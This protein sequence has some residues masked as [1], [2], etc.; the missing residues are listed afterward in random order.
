MQTQPIIYREAI[1]KFSKLSRERFP[2][3]IPLDYFPT[4]QSQQL[5]PYGP[6]PH[7]RECALNYFFV[8]TPPD[9]SGSTP[10]PIPIADARRRIRE[11]HYDRG[12][13]VNAMDIE[14]KEMADC[15][16]RFDSFSKSEH[17]KGKVMAYQL[18]QLGF[19]FVG[20]RNA[21]G[22]LRC[23]F[24]RRTI[25]M[26]VTDDVSYIEKD[27]DRRLIALLN[28]HSHLSATCP[29]SIGLNGDDKRF[30]ADD[31][32]RVVDPLIRIGVIQLSF[33]NTCQT[34]HPDINALR[35]SISIKLSTFA[36]GN[37]EL[38]GNNS[39]EYFELLA[40]YDYEMLSLFDLELDFEINTDFVDDLTPLSTPVDYLIGATPKTRDFWPLH[41]RVGT[42]LAQ[43]W[44]SQ[45]IAQANAP[46]LSPESLANAGFFY[47]GTADNVSCFWCGLG[48]N[49]WERTDD[50]FN[51]HARFTPRC[52]WLL[53]TRGRQRV[54]A[55]YMNAQ[56]GQAGAAGIQ[57]VK[58]ADYAF[59]KDV[60]EIPGGS[61]SN[62]YMAFTIL[63]HVITV[64]S[65]IQNCCCF[66]RTTRDKES[67][68]GALSLN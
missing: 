44:Q 50:P 32:A 59:I 28:R 35:D 26:F 23:S 33:P 42:Y 67:E 34:I 31:I 56:G 18:A 39:T 58:L 16:K 41:M 49:H 45:S 27:W 57:Q 47:T 7:R 38:E 10:A 43:T 24:C 3:R 8:Q 12:T 53:R 52:T 64:K 61:F 36:D 20:D 6:L 54:K 15:R 17:L 25:H 60:E 40:E 21:V 9:Q 68:S 51:E 11:V 62:R 14:A 37:I 63:F 48:L 29:F 65:K 4:P 5:L 30:S 1:E 13:I 22:K 19:F 2:I 46:A 55:L 66:Y